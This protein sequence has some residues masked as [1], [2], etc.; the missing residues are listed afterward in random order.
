[1]PSSTSLLG[2]K[3][4]KNKNK[5]LLYLKQFLI[6]YTYQILWI[7]CV[8][9]EGHVIVC[10]VYGTILGLRNWLSSTFL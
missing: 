7:K 4:K 6:L 10:I 8:E 5:N 1:M 3:K 9:D 2:H